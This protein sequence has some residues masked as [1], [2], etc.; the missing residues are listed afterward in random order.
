MHTPLQRVGGLNQIVAS[1]LFVIII[2]DLHLQCVLVDSL[3]VA[4]LRVSTQ[5]IVGIL[6]SLL[7]VALEEVE[8][9]SKRIGSIAVEVV[10]RNLIL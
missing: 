4:K 9:C 10:S 8:T 2:V 1:Q 3:P 5:S 7:V 6:Q